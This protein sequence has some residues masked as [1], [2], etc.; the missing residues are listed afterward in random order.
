MST[1]QS[2]SGATEAKASGETQENQTTKVSSGNDTVA[3]ETHQ[4]LLG[5]KKKVQAR[6]DAIEAE[7]QKL[8]E[9]KLHGEGKKD[10]LLTEYKKKYDD[11]EGKF[12]GS[13]GKFAMKTLADAIEKEAL[14]SGCLNPRSLSKLVDMSEIEVS[15]DFEVDADQLKKAV[16][17]VK[18]ENPFMFSKSAPGF[19]DVTKTVVGDTNT[20][21]KSIEKMS[22]KDK[23]KQLVEMN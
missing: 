20:K 19:V 3:Y 23:I 5:E 8:K 9:E 15:E 21:P 4:K 1:E 16:E 10:E 12:K 18:T 14:K 7:F 13:V 2:T 6:A 22:V 17:K 11:L